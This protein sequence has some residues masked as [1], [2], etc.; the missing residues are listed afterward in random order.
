M[1]PNP[2]DSQMTS[3]WEINFKINRNKEKYNDEI[4]SLANTMN[5]FP[6]DGSICFPMRIRWK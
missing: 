3:D 5:I 1:E 2:L 4:I 6:G